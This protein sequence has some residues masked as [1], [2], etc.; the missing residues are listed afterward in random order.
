VRRR[1][2]TLGRLAVAVAGLVSLGGVAGC[3]AARNELGPNTAPCYVAI[4]AATAAVKGHGHLLGVQFYA[5]TRVPS[6]DP[7]IAATART[8]RTARVADVCVVAFGGSFTAQDVVRGRGRPAGRYAVVVLA[9]PSGRV[10]GTVVESRL[11]LPFG[12]SHLV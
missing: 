1:A 5:S 12:H 11:R 10:L 8:A 6:G 4:P 7:N 9:Y 2:P 3:S